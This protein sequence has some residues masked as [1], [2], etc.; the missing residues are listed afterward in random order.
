MSKVDT[1]DTESQDI[2]VSWSLDLVGLIMGFLMRPT[3]WQ[4]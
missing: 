3:P 2:L 4:V 1:D